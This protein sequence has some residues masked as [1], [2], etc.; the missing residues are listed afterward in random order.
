M[1]PLLLLLSALTLLSTRL[2]AEPMF[3]A[4][5]EWLAHESALTFT[6][7]PQNVEIIPLKG[8]S[9]TR[10]RFK[11]EKCI[12][13]PL[14]AGDVITVTSL[15]WEGR[16]EEKKFR[17]AVENQRRVLALASIAKD[18]D[19]LIGGSYTFPLESL[20]RNVF[21]ADEPVEKIYDAGGEAVR[22][23]NEVLQRVEAQVRKEKELVGRPGFGMIRE[24][25]V[26]A[27]IRS[28]D[29]GKDLYGGS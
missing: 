27:F 22:D 17:D 29:A 11:I 15:E 28:S 1:K 13:G 5:P 19:H 10:V 23:F 4:T 18:S 7:V 3:G 21:F 16:E 6:G 2:P 20:W 8:W 26:E 24:K 9:M 25:E 14:S 12:K